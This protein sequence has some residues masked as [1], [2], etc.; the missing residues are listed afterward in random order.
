MLC[1]LLLGQ[2]QTALIQVAGQ[3]PNGDQLAVDQ[4]KDGMLPGD[5]LGKGLALPHLF[6]DVPQQTAPGG[7]RVFCRQQLQPADQRQPGLQQGG[8]LA[9]ELDQGFA[10]PLTGGNAFPAVNLAGL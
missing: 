1:F 5:N 3:F 6:A 7:R 10:A 4:R 8:K 2:L 9:G